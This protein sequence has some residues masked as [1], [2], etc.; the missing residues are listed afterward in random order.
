MAYRKID[1]DAILTPEVLAEIEELAALGFNQVQIADYLGMSE[2]TFSNWKHKYPELL[3]SYKG[4]KANR[5]KHVTRTFQQKIDEGDTSSLIFYLKTQMGWS[6]K[7][8]E[9]EQMRLADEISSATGS[10]ASGASEQELIEAV[11]RYVLGARER[12][13]T[14]TESDRSEQAVDNGEE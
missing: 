5:H 12:I 3:R 11:G 6:E 10:L 4:G 13:R 14:L 2:D 1:K 8:W 9:E 7:R